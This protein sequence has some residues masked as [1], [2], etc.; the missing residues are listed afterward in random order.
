[1]E[2]ETMYLVDPAVKQAIHAPNK[3]WT[4][5]IP[6]LFG[7]GTAGDPSKRSQIYPNPETA[8]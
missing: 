3:N 4:L 7:G 5:S 6:Y 8:L 1:M 2:T